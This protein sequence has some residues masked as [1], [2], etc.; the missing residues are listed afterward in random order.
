MKIEYEIRIVREMIRLYCRLKEGNRDTCPGCENLARYAE[1]RLR[2]CPFSDSKGS[3]R[4]CRIHCYRPDMKE[5]IKTVMRFSGPRMLFYHPIMA[6]RH[7]IG[8]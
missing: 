6:I 2:H 3:C 5:K 1:S 8:K 7:L 4:K